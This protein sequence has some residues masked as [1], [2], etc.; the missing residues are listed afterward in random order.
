[1]K[2][3]IFPALLFLILLSACN[4]KDELSGQ[5]M[6]IAYVPAHPSFPEYVDDPK[7]YHP[8]MT[9]EFLDGN[10]ANE[11]LHDHKGSYELN[12]DNLIVLFERDDESIEIEFIIKDSDKDFSKYAAQISDVNF[13]KDPGIVSHFDNLFFSLD[14]SSPI[15]FLPQ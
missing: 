13:E 5:T 12:D 10:V 7:R 11:T 9:L 2:R 14:K 6:N 4:K 8:L 3:I 15:E 1:M